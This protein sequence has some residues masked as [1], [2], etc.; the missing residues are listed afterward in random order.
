MP[1]IPLLALWIAWLVQAVLSALQVRKFARLF[2]PEKR[3]RFETYRPPVAVVVPFK[4]VDIGLEANIAGLCQQAYPAYELLLV[5]DSEQDPACPILRQQVARYPQCR[6]QLLVAGPAQADEGQKIH[7][8]LFAIDYLTQRLDPSTKEPPVWVFADSDA[9]PG[10]Q[11]LADMVGPLAQVQ[12]TGLTTGYRWLIPTSKTGQPNPTRW[13]QLASV[14]NS[15]VACAYGRDTLNHAWGGSMAV[16]SDIAIRGRLRDRLTGALCDDYQFSRMSRDLGLRV[17]FMPWCLVATPVDFDLKGL[18]NFAHR[19]YL[20]TRVYAPKL[21]AA[22]LGIT[23]LYVLGWVSAW[24]YLVVSL[25][26]KTPAE[27]GAWIWPTGVLALAFLTNQIR[28]TFRKKAVHNALGGQTAAQLQPTLTLDRWTTPLWMTFHWLL[29]C[30]ALCGRT[31][32][33]RGISYRLFGPQH[34]EKLKTD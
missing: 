9:I 17:Y 23:S 1:P 32:R 7:N 3:D 34:V 25:V 12:K 24:A 21:F 33:W 14:M 10:P 26:T 5:V 2:D 30:R 11:W 31:M 4:G 22:A 27:D 18:I 6:A 20:L 19:Q 8:Q 29:M 28:A 13:S 15:S 16:R